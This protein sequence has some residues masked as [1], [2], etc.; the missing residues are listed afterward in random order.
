MKKIKQEHVITLAGTFIVAV[1]ILALLV[2]AIIYPIWIVSQGAEVWFLLL[3][4]P[5]TIGGNL[6][7]VACRPFL[8]SRVKEIQEYYDI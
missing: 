1:S 2:F 4:V 6:I 3:C 7:A 5:L 8:E